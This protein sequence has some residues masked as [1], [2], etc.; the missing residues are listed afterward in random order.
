ML[1][2]ILKHCFKDINSIIFM[3]RKERLVNKSHIKMESRR[4]FFCGNDE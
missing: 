1:S 2:D 3:G 4:C